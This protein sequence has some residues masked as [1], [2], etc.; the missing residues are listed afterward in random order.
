MREGIPD[1]KEE[2]Y[3]SSYSDSSEKGPEVYNVL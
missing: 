1:T 3:F 2:D